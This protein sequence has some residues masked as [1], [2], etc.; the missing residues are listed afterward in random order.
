HLQ[1]A[2]TRERTSPVRRLYGTNV[3]VEG[4]APYCE[5]LLA[6]EGFLDPWA[7]LFQVRDLLWRALRVEIDV[8]LHRGTLDF[9]QAVALLV[10]G[11][12]F[13]RP[14]AVA[15]VTRY[16]VSP[17][18]PLTYLVGRQQLLDLRERAR[19]RFGSAF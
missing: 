13:E 5:Q 15:E 18:Q 16:A 14:D 12:A 10:D 8:R 19:Q 11:V 6:D 2:L 1:L 7:R 3:L 9:E 17:T 4:W